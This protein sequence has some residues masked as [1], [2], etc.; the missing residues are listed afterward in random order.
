MIV[1]PPNPLPEESSELNTN[2]SVAAHSFSENHVV[3]LFIYETGSSPPPGEKYLAYLR[4]VHRRSN[5]AQIDFING[6]IEAINNGGT[7]ADYRSRRNDEAPGATG[8]ERLIGYDLKDVFPRGGSSRWD[9]ELQQIRLC[10]Q[11]P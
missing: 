8:G 2:T 10:V 11:R 7:Y 5:T 3:N 6:V 1:S 9:D 4:F